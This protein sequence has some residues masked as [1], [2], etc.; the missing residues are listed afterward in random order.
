MIRWTDSKGEE[1]RKGDCVMY[2]ETQFPGGHAE[3]TI[4]AGIVWELTPD[5]VDVHFTITGKRDVVPAANLSVVGKDGYHEA[6]AEET[7]EP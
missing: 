2:C 6:L 1:I 5:G 7:K 4:R 3:E